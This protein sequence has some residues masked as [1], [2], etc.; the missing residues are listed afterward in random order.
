MSVCN[1]RCDWV[2]AYSEAMWNHIYKELIAD[3]HRLWEQHDSRGTPRKWRMVDH[4]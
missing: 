4:K 1:S 3:R 2:C